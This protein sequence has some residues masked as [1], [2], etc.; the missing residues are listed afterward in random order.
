MSG[1]LND[2]GRIK[3]VVYKQL[4]MLPRRKVPKTKGQIMASNSIIF[5]NDNAPGP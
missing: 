3:G 2:S 4:Q 5:Y 1:S